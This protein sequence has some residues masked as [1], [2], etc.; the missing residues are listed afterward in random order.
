M[1]Y[2]DLR[3]Y[4]RI[5]KTSPKLAELPNDF[6]SQLA[7]LISQNKDSYSGSGSTTDLKTLENILKIA[8]DLYDRR[9]QKMIMRSLSDSRTNTHELK[10]LLSDEQDLYV[11]MK[12]LLKEKRIAFDEV[13]TGKTS[14]KIKNSKVLDDKFGATVIESKNVQKEAEDLNTVL[15]RTI[16]KLPK[17]VSSDLKEFGPFDEEQ[18]ISI[19]KKEA[20][21][22][23]KR[24]F[25]ELI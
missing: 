4:H 1:N 14:K 7:E 9:E 8:R 22:L 21:L 5:E 19:P 17:F 6:E 16:K 20:D 11:Q 25:I 24:G 2:D 3:R 10:N 18:V 23:S 13:L 15:V 12:Q